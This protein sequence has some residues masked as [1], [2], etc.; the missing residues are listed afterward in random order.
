MYG[1]SFSEHT[2]S[3]IESALCEYSPKNVVLSFNGGKDCTLLLHFYAAVLHKNHPGE[4][5]NLLFMETAESFD[6]VTAFMDRTKVSFSFVGK[7]SLESSENRLY[8]GFVA[9]YFRSYRLFFCYEF[10]CLKC[11]M[12]NVFN[13]WFKISIFR[14]YRLIMY[15]R[16]LC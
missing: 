1:F 15:C 3:V 16:L 13:I 2:L 5:V 8:S 10:F 14:A 11:A 9:V 6:E 7:N 4:K 12:E